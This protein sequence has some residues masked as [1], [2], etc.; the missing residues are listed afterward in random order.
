MKLPACLTA[1]H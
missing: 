1:A